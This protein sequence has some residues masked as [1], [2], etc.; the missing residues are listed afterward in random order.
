MQSFLV[1]VFVFEESGE[2][3]AETC[4]CS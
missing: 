2:V 3:D 1:E 4:T